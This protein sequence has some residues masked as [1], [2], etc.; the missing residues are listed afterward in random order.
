MT[1]KPVPPDPSKAGSSLCPGP[2][3]K[4]LGVRVWGLLTNDMLLTSLKNFVVPHMNLIM[5]VIIQAPVLA[6]AR[7]FTRVPQE[8][9]PSKTPQDPLQV[10]SQ[11]PFCGACPT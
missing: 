6:S 4:A 2:F 8:D 1:M 7:F 11:C 5:L 10:P 3:L 9:R